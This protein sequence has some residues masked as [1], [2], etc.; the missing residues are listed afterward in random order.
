[1]NPVTFACALILTP[2]NVIDIK[3]APAL[4]ERA[5]R[6]RYLLADE[7]YDADFR[8]GIPLATAMAFWL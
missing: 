2:G 4:L 3:A 7:G 6:R 1:M 8:S 5:G